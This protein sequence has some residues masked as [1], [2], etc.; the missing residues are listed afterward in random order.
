MYLFITS[1]YPNDKAKEAATIYLKAMK[2]YP[3]NNSLAT[4]LVPVAVRSTL[5]GIKVISIYDV[6]K[7]K[8]EDAE[9]L[10]VNR[11]VMF[12]DIQGYRWSVKPYW[13][14][15]DALKLIGM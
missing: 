10:A 8:F 1:T 15:E 6:K 2:K 7:G 9:A 13:N 12:N 4:P 14:L 11:M 3:D 5:I